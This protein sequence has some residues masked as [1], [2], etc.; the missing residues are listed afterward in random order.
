[1]ID[2]GWGAPDLWKP[3]EVIFNSALSRC[4]RNGQWPLVLSNLDLPI[5]A[6]K[7]LSS[8][9]TFWFQQCGF[10]LEAVRRTQDLCKFSEPEIS[11]PT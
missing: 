6:A 9:P 1:M 5:G 4:A 3:A 10:P 2:T 11:D 8:R 7:M